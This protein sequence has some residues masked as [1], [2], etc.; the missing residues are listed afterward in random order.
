MAFLFRAG[1][2]HSFRARAL[3]ILSELPR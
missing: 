2:L 3:S 1:F